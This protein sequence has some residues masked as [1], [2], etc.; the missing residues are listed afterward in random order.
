MPPL[1]RRQSRLP[2]LG[3]KL[4]INLIA[5]SDADARGWW[6]EQTSE[7]ERASWA[8]AA[9]VIGVVQRIAATS[10]WKPEF[11]WGVHPA[12]HERAGPVQANPIHAS[13]LVKLAT[14]QPHL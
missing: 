12:P 2:S 11:A 7:A 5:V 9:S 8:G 13:K 1:A 4:M 6:G 10:A 14:Q 3:K